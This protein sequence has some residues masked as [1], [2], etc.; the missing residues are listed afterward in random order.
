MAFDISGVFKD[1]SI[2]S[3][4]KDEL[5]Y[6]PYANIIP[7]KNNGYSMDGLEELA[8]SIEIVGL[9]QPLRVRQLA[10]NSVG[11]ISGHRRHA[12]IGL[13]ID[14]GSKAFDAGIPCIV[15]SGAASAALRELQ[16]LLGNADNRKLTA[17]DEALQAERISD[18]LRRLEDEGYQF[19]GRHRDWVAKLSGMSRTKIA[20]LN[21]IKN[22]LQPQLIDRFNAGSLGITAAYRISQE[23]PE[24][25]QELLRRSGPV[26]GNLT[27]AQLEEAISLCKTPKQPEPEKSSSQ[28]AE[29]FEK[30][31]AF[32]GSYLDSY[33]EKRKKESDDYFQMLRARADLLLRCSR[34]GDTRSQ[35]IETL[36]RSFRN[37]YSSGYDNI[38]QLEGSAK[39]LTLKADGQDPL[40]RTWTEVYDMLCTI[41]L[42][43]AVNGRNEAANDVE[44]V[45]E[46][47]TEAESPE[48][49]ASSLC[50]KGTSVK[51]EISVKFLGWL[52]GTA[53]DGVKCWAKFMDEE[54]SRDFSMM[55]TYDAEMDA[56]WS[57][58][59]IGKYS[60]IDQTCIGWGPLPEDNAPDIPGDLTPQAPANP[61]SESS[62]APTWREGEPETEG[63]YAVKIRIGSFDTVY[64]RVLYWDEG[65]WWKHETEDAP[66]LDDLDRVV[67][68]YPLPE[69][70]I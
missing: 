3:K 60:T 14:R 47:V 9:Q 21:S 2:P 11:I 42:N 31:D 39:G 65:E 43:R 44:D 22:N 33:L 20:Q 5:R 15:E 63:W 29:S 12:A 36:K 53:P 56:W 49:E 52:T 57:G 13:L 59:N 26:L 40:F 32:V 24:I 69:E 34:A 4:G 23:K 46:D 6:I 16:L 48:E 38:P 58:A 30:V 62:A 37:Y 8:R 17:A 67:C 19:P 66:A 54:T 27:D 55:A 10:D 18:C 41:A 1:V 35:G 68:W 45:E 61:I 50:Q 25:Q 64:R 7:D 28:K 51:Q 70:D